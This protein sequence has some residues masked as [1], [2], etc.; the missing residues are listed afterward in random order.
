MGNHPPPGRPAGEVEELYKT[1]GRVLWAVLYAQCCDRE[2]A[3]DALHEAFVRL[4]QSN[5]TPI[6][7]V[8]AWLLQVAKNW[9]CDAA[10]R[11][12]RI[13]Q[14]EF[15]LDEIPAGDDDPASLVC[16]DELRAQ[17]RQALARLDE[18]DREVLVLRYA[19]EWPSRRIAEQL[20]SSASAIDMRLSRARRRLASALDALG[21]SRETV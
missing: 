10:R 6:R 7:N 15:P 17:V 4:Q 5:G 14:A 16:A 2:L 8:P 12:G 11:K 9:L 21:V 1:H 13:A 3:R 18:G 19:L 20:G